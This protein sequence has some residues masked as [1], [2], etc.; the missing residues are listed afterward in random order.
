MEMQHSKQDNVDVIKLPQRI[1]MA[2]AK[3]A[4]K[5]LKQFVQKAQ[6]LLALDMSE[7]EFVDSSGLAV[8]VN[9]LQ[10]TRKNAGEVCIFGMQETVR[11]LFEL[12]RLHTVFPIEADRNSALRRLQ[13]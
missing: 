8:L 3:S 13:A 12:T 4:R 11:A 5:Y 7:T 10:G 1:M 2:D 6:P 9:T